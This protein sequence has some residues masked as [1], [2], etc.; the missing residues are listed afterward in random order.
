[1]SRPEW[2]DQPDYHEPVVA[3]GLRASVSGLTAI[4]LDD[5][6]YEIRLGHMVAQA[7]D[8]EG[9]QKAIQHVTEHWLYGRHV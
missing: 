6:T 8:L 7:N 5:G 9:A 1:M 2:P 4:Q 3:P